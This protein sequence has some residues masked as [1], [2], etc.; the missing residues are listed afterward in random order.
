MVTSKATI[1]RI[2]EIVQKHYSRLVVSVLGRDALSE[3]ELK[4]LQSLGVDTSN[5]DSL[6]SLVYYHN[7]INHPIDEVS[8]TSVEDMK[9]QQGVRGLKPE[10]QAH[11]YTVEN[12]NDKT[13]QYIEKLKLDVMTR[14]EGII[15]ENNDSY[16]MDALQ[17]LDRTDML[18][19]LM[20]ES[21]LGK[22]K[23]K[24]KDTAGDGNRDWTRVAVT[25]MSN[26]IG[27]ASVDRIV[28]DNIGADLEDIYVFRITVKDAKTCKWCRRFYDD[29]DGSPKL[30]KLSTLLGNGSNYGKKT[31]SWMPVIGATHPNER[32]SQ[33]IELKPGYKLQSD[34]SVTYI[35]LDKWKPY[36]LDKL[37]K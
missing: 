25:E 28:S 2:R 12:I 36:V 29:R 18:D 23:S 31:D 35:G 10:G 4:E 14:V 9:A 34:G 8:P 5:E 3:K 16:K 11:D 21:T 7:F 26:A 37:Q 20:K 17:N 33:M 22:L 13:K 27:V 15:R 19:E 32:C 1:E 6:M 30:Y 24:L